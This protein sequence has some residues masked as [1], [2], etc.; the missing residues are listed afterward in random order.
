M[1][2]KELPSEKI[3]VG[4]RIY[5]HR[6]G[7]GTITD[8]SKFELDRLLRYRF[9]DGWTGYFALESDFEVLLENGLPVYIPEERVLAMEAASELEIW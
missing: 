5:H 1:L 8:V 7:T 6:C 2:V 9:D 4:L 3:N